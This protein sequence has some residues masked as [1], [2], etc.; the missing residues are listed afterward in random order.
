[1]WRDHD[2][3]GEVDDGDG[4]GDKEITSGVELLSVEQ[5]RQRE[6][7]RT[8]KSAVRQNELI[9]VVQPHQTHVVRHRRQHHHPYQHTLTHYSCLFQLYL[10]AFFYDDVSG[11]FTLSS[12]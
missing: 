2:E 10:C 7:D 4:G 11:W 3:V 6:R 1:M 8:S 5:W 12:I 9:N